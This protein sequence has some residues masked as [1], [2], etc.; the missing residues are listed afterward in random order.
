MTTSRFSYRGLSSLP[1]WLLVDERD[2]IVASIR[3]ETA[4]RARDLFRE[5]GLYG[6]RVVRASDWTARQTARGR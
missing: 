2:E 1:A 3:A 4:F 6:A 5:R